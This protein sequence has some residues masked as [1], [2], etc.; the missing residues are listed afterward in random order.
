ML[1]SR[2]TRRRVKELWRSEGAGVTGREDSCSPPPKCGGCAGASL[3]VCSV[4][5][6]AE[7]QNPSGTHLQQ[8][9]CPDVLSRS[10]ACCSTPYRAGVPLPRLHLQGAMAWAH[11]GG[12]CVIWRMEV[13]AAHF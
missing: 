9:T 7:S 12:N 3:Q 4:K 10:Q 5:T 1:S 2:V 13:W 11:L 8:P 6:Q